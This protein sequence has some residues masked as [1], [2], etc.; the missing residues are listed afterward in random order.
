[1]FQIRIGLY[2]WSV[3]IVSGLILLNTLGAPPAASDQVVDAMT[4]GSAK[5]VFN[6]AL[7]RFVPSFARKAFWPS[8]AR[9]RNWI[10]SQLVG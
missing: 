8:F 1:M 3:E 2:D 6:Q 4:A 5:P 10:Y 9:Y 7:S